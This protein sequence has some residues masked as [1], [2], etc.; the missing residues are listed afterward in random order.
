MKE[1]RKREERHVHRESLFP[2]KRG[3]KPLDW[4]ETERNLKEKLERGKK[5]ELTVERKEVCHFHPSGNAK[6]PIP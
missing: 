1:L 4:W 2:I 3:G 6:G 5:G